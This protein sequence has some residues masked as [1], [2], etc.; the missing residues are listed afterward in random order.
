MSS[1]EFAGNFA[2]LINAGFPCVYIPSYEEERITKLIGQVVQSQ[3]MIKVQR[4]VYE[5]AQTSGLV[6]EKE[7]IRNTTAPMQLLDHIERA[8]EAA[9][10][11]LKDF[12]IFFGAD[13]HTHPDYGVIRR[14]R[15]IIPDMKASRKTIVFIA[16]KL[17]IPCD[18]EKEI[19]VLDFALPNE[20]ELE[21][22]LDGL[23]ANLSPQ[24]IRL[25]G[26]EKT[27][28]VRSAL[29]LTLQE[30]ENA[31]CRAIVRQKGLDVSAISVIHE[32]KNQVVKKTGVLEFVK[33]NLSIEDIGGL[34]NMKNW[35]LQI[36]RAHV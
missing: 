25:A 26:D 22:V 30:A 4:E 11:I 3:E 28:L 27:Q 5:W 23:M 19:S 18:M 9:I 7:K 32:E 14:L 16:P 29:G 17:V 1:R 20:E 2:N 34:D 13:R 12:H 24:N 8:E 35:L 10:Y 6:G 15:D 36:G 21:E 31:F 33:S